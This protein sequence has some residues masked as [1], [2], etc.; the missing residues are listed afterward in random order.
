MPSGS[1]G[2]APATSSGSIRSRS[3][4]WPGSRSA[5]ASGT[6]SSGPARSGRRASSTAP[7]AAST[8]RRT[9]SSRPSRSAR[10]RV[11]C[12]TARARSGSV[13]TPAR[14]S[15]GSTRR[16]TGAKAVPVGL[17]SPDSVAVSDTAIWVTSSADRFAVRLDPRTMRVVARVKVGLGPSNAAIA[18]DGSVFVP[19][20]ADGTVSRIDRGPQQGGRDLQGRAEAVPGGDRLRRRLGAAGGREA[21][22]ALPR[23]LIRHHRRRGRAAPAFDRAHPRR[24]GGSCSPRPTRATSSRSRSTRRPSVHGR[25]LRPRPGTVAR[26]A[27]T[28][29]TPVGL[30]NLGRRGARTWLGGVGVVAEPSAS[31]G[32]ASCSRARCSSRPARSGATEMALEVIVENHAGDLALREARLRPDA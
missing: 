3:R 16:R 14:A 22:G 5:R 24:A 12:A 7:S 25:R 28:D 17:L 2:T 32:S 29:G 19:N 8:R 30:A 31:R 18:G 1:T 9:R 27:S 23:R 20:N 13:A 21:G 11:R 26:C 6:S 4:S 10:R 15:I